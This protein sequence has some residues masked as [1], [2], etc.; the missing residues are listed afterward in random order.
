MSSGTQDA[1]KSAPPKLPEVEVYFPAALYGCPMN[2]L[3]VYYVTGDR[4]GAGCPAVAALNHATGM[5][6]L[7]ALRG[8]MSEK[9]SAVRHID[10]PFFKDHANVLRRDGAWDYGPGM[11]PP[12]GGLPT[13][14]EAAA[15][16]VIRHWNNNCSLETIEQKVRPQLT[17][18]GE[19]VVEPKTFV[20]VTLKNYVPRSRGK[21]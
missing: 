10:D 9:K 7:I 16:D 3:V 19:L 13:L 12:K 15:L 14:I 4:G 2:D 5:L 18:L 6:D 20:Q 11:S 8:A 17:V 21:N 1:Q